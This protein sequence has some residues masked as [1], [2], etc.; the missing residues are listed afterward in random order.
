[1]RLPARVRPGSHVR[2]RGEDV[3]RGAVVIPA[4]TRLAPQHL[5]VAA[6]LGLAGLEV[7]APLPVALFSSGDEL[8]EAGGRTGPGQI[9]DANRPMLAAWLADLPVTLTDLGILPDRRE[10]VEA[11][12]LEAARGH[13]LVLTS[14]GASTG[15]EDHLSRLLRTRG[16]VLF[17]RV[18]MKPGRPLGFGR[19]EDAFVFVLPGN[20]VAAALSFLLF[21]RPFLLALAGAPFALPPALPLPAAFALDKRAD[22]TEFARARLVRTGDGGLAVERITR[23]GSGILT[24]LIEADGILELP[25][26]L[27]CVRPGDPVLYRA[28]SELGCG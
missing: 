4:G 26:G 8:V 25:A 23:E 11:A 1:V 18:A 22:R 10:V 21:A 20:P 17:W 3:A 2:R 16:E 19:L 5:G 6:E 27:T 14:G 15:D 7:R 13:R 12:V 28:L 9:F 24:S